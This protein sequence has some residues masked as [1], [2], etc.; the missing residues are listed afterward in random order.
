MWQTVTVVWVCITDKVPITTHS[1]HTFVY[2]LSGGFICHWQQRS[3]VFQCRRHPKTSRKHLDENFKITSYSS[4]HSW[5]L[6]RRTLSEQCQ[7]NQKSHLL[8]VLLQRSSARALVVIFQSLLGCRCSPG[9]ISWA[10]C[11][12]LRVGTVLGSLPRYYACWKI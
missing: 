2:S 9:N 7:P 5:K 6:E 11:I 4:R 8:A 3:L 10:V 12:A 1:C